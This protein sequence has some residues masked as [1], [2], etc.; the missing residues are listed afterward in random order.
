VVRSK[1]RMRFMV[2]SFLFWHLPFFLFGADFAGEAP[3]SCLKAT[4]F[5]A[6]FYTFSSPLCGRSS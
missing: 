3:K 5:R 2:L 1:R 6:V 4:R